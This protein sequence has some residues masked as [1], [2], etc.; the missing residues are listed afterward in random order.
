MIVNV[1]NSSAVGGLRGRRE[2]L[3]AIVLILTTEL[4]ES[5]CFRQNKSKVYLIFLDLC[6]FPTGKTIFVFIIHGRFRVSLRNF[7]PPPAGED[8]I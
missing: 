6:A 3:T 2:K 7:S 1:F 5:S 8:Q 4:T